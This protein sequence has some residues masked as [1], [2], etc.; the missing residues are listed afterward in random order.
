MCD[1]IAMK[2]KT[3]KGINNSLLCL[4]QGVLKEL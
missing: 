2:V 1:L 3:V 4:A